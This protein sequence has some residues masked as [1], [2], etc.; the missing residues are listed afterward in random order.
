MAITEQAAL[1]SESVAV[2]K[3]K[4]VELSDEEEIDEES[5]GILN[6][7]VRRVGKAESESLVLE[8][9]SDATVLDL[10]Q[11]IVEALEEQKETAVPTERQR[12][13]FS[14]KMLR[15][16]TLSLTEDLKMEAGDD[17]KYF[18]HLTPLPKGAAPSTRT[19]RELSENPLSPQEA[20]IQQVRARQRR[21]KRQDQRRELSDPA[22]YHPYALDLSGT[23]LPAAAAAAAHASTS[24][25]ASRAATAAAPSVDAAI[26]S[27]AAAAEQSRLL[28]EAANRSVL[29]DALQAVLMAQQQQNLLSSANG[30]TVAAAA[31]APAI[32]PTRS[33]TPLS[34]VRRCTTSLGK[35]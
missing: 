25:A 14:G 35:W 33:T 13:I 19:T 21:R 8:L 20:T 29:P 18:V 17:H 34:P 7:V 22:A 11:K 28:Q 5:S 31:A 30:N 23:L 24:D 32:S 12:L 6:I 16:E 9:E 27:V 4:H 3:R 1:P 26:L 2:R 15:D 10:K